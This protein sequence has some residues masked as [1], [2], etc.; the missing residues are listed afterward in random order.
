MVKIYNTPEK[1]TYA[2]PPCPSCGEGQ[3]IAIEWTA[4][5][6]SGLGGSRYVIQTL[7]CL[8]CQDV[9]T[10]YPRSSSS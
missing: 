6:S 3:R 10:G 9:R 5:F 4:W 1:A 7:T 8:N 2:P